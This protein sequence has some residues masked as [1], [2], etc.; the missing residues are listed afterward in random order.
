M[1]FGIM[2]LQKIKSV[3]SLRATLRHA[4][5]E[6]D[7]PNA[8]PNKLHLNKY[9]GASSVA[10]AIAVYHE[11]IKSIRVRK[12][13]VVAIEHLI[14]ASPEFFDNATREQK[15]AF[16][17]KSLNW[18]KDVYGDENVF[19]SGL[20][21]DEK[22]PHL[23]AYVVP[24]VDKKLNARH[25]IGGHKNRLSELQT[26]FHKKCCVEFGL[27]RGLIGSKATHTEIRHFYSAIKEALNLPSKTT[28]EKIKLLF[29][30]GLDKIVAGAAA[31]AAAARQAMYRTERAVKELK[32]E[33]ERAQTATERLNAAENVIAMM[34]RDKIDREN[35]IARLETFKNLV[36]GNEDLLAKAEFLRADPKNVKT[37]QEDLDQ[38]ALPSSDAQL[39]L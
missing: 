11:K 26:D 22:T 7:T 29:G 5:R 32:K 20:H 13:A 16:F 21:M 31:S 17:N 8:D 35:Y 15:I 2:R 24:V 27:Q 34:E 23:F 38:A 30:D 37:T 18:L 19:V 6:Q 25:F 36:D 9:L 1:A 39:R 12:N 3:F 14:T 28:A 4:Y 10:Q 33:K